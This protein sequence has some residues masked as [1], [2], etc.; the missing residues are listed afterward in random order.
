MAT[1]A[2]NAGFLHVKYK[3]I[4][5]VRG[6]GG[7]TTHGLSQNKLRKFWLKAIITKIWNELP[8]EVKNFALIL[9]IQKEGEIELTQQLICLAS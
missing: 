1:I 7:G 5:G 4:S 3:T 2:D 6:W 9:Y 8:D